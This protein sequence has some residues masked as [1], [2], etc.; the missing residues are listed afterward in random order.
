MLRGIRPSVGT[1]KRLA[2]KQKIVDF[3]NMR[4]LADQSHSGA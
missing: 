2:M 4:V 1:V 3:K